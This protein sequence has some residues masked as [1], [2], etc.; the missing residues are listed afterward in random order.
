MTN[1]NSIEILN[2]NCTSLI[3]NKCIQAKRF[4]DW[5]E[6]QNCDAETLVEISREMSN[7]FYSDHFQIDDSRNFFRLCIDMCHNFQFLHS[8]KDWDR[9]DFLTEIIRFS[10]LVKKKLLS[11]PDWINIDFRWSY[12][13]EM[14]YDLLLKE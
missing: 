3:K 10:N 2:Y 14:V 7:I 13:K 6:N 4:C 11:Y 1:M 5:C 9:D 8:E 12:G